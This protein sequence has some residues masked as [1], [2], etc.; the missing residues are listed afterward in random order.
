[1]VEFVLIRNKSSTVKFWK[2]KCTRFYKIYEN[3]M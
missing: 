1:M 3:Q 2:S